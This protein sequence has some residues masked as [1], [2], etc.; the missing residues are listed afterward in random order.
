MKFKNIILSLVFLSVLGCSS[1]LDV[2]ANRKEYIDNDKSNSLLSTSPTTVNFGYINRYKDERMPFQVTNLNSMAFALKTFGFGANS[3][4]SIPGIELPLEIEKKNTAGSIQLFHIRFFSSEIGEYIDTLETN[5]LTNPKL[6]VQAI[7][8]DIYCDDVSFGSID[9]NNNVSEFINIYNYTNQELVVE[10][11]QFADTSEVFT[12]NN[13]TSYTIPPFD[14]SGE[15]GKIPISFS[16][17]VDNIYETTAEIVFKN[18]LQG[19]L[20][21]NTIH[22]EAAT[23]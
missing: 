16:S 7:V 11:I 12:V 19:K 22:V 17:K 10:S 8:P 5:G 6:L 20:V 21:K 1:P 9:I 23:I 18:T 15:P 3:K 2:P 4:F 13:N 14:L